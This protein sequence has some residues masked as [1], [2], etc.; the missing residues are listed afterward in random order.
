M[1]D[2]LRQIWGG[3]EETTTRRLSG[4]GIDNI[5]VP[6]RRDYAADRQAELAGQT[7]PPAQA[8]FAALTHR[9]SAA[10]QRAA[11]KDARRKQNGSRRGTEPMMAAEPP[12]PPLSANA[13][14]EGAPEAAQNLIK[15]LKATE[16]RIDRS[17]G[18]YTSYMAQAQERSGKRKK[19]FGLF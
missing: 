4:R 13:Y 16:A 8:A 17:T 7:T 10:E 5:E 18:L 12:P 9:L 15:G 2:R 1:S 11:R 6:N 19:F 3:F 14:A